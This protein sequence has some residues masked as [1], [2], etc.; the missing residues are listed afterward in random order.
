M[1]YPYLA[2][3]PNQF[4]AGIQPLLTKR[5]KEGI[6]TIFVDQERIFDYYGFG[7]YGPV[8]IQTAV[9]ACRPKYL[10]LLG[11]TNYDYLNYSGL[12]VDPLCPAFLVSTSNWAQT[13]SDSIFGDLGRGYPEVAVGRL[14][15]N[16][17]GEL[18][19]AVN[20]ILTYQGVS[21]LG[22]RVHAVADRTDPAVGDFGALLDSVSQAHPDLTWQRN[23]LGTTSNDPAAVTSVLQTAAGGSADLVL[24]SGHGNSVRLGKTDPRILDVDKVQLWTGNTVLL[25]ST[26]TA[27][28]MA[29]D[30]PGFK[31][32]AMQALTQPQGGIS[33]SIASSTYVTADASVRAGAPSSP[34][35]PARPRR[36]AFS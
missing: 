6:R 15:A 26:C 29:N 35:S 4:G 27:N 28:W 18:S 12:N 32:I 25:Q 23:Y 7:R 16:D 22:F 1:N 34:H 33:A 8:P 13:T 19:G 36:T 9:R 17:A 2:I 31:S 10:L 5:S 30:A 24:Y 20:H 21:T 11:R 3:G 14:P